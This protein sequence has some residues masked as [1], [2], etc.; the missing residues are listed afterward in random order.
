M[1]LSKLIDIAKQ[2]NVDIDD[3]N[4][5]IWQQQLTEEEKIILSLRAFDNHQTSYSL[6]T[7][8]LNYSVSGKMTSELT[9]II[10][11]K[12]QTDLSH[13]AVNLELS[14]E[15]SLFFDIF[16]SPECQI[17]AWN[18]FLENN[19]TDKFLLIM[20][21]NAAPIP[22]SVKDKLYEKL[23]TIHDFHIPIYKS[24]RDSCTY[25]HGYTVELNKPK[26]LETILKLNIKEHIPELD[27]EKG[28]DTYSQILSFLSTQNGR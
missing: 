17:E 26:A 13:S 2:N 24:I 4:E 12:Y 27:K 22:Y 10:Y 9:K 20:L 11:K 1:T 8:W 5:L 14:M 18:Y 19:P 15:Y 6:M 21:K 28:R 23:F 3:Y 7:L 16:Q 25:T